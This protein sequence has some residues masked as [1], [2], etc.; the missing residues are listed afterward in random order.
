MTE[1]TEKKSGAGRP[2]KKILPRKDEIGRAL[3]DVRL[4]T[5]D[6]VAEATGTT[7]LTIRAYC[8]DGRLHAKK[9]GNRWMIPESG[10]RAYFEDGEPAPA[11]EPPKIQ[12]K[13]I[14]GTK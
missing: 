8:R 11:P 4:F 1:K 12:P 3:G 6:E 10:L 9:W 7:A 13:R 5:V 2:R 14:G